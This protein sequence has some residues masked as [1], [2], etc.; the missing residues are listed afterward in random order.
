MAEVK[1]PQIQAL[2]QEPAEELRTGILGGRLRIA[3]FRLDFTDWTIGDKAFLVDLPATAIVNEI[4]L[5]SDD[6]TDT[7][8]VNVGDVNFPDGLLETVFI[9]PDTVLKAGQ[10]A[11]ISGNGLRNAD[12]LKPLWEAL[13]YSS[14]AAARGRIRLILTSSGAQ[15]GILFGSIGYV[16]D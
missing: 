8:T 10:G 5:V 2:D 9:N 7:Q 3:K 1:S 16:T 6:T 15:Q 12:F 13:G 11:F 4:R 14:R